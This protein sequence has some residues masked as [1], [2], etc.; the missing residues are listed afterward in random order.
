MYSFLLFSI[1]LIQISFVIFLQNF[2]VSTL[3][4]ILPFDIYKLF[5]LF[6]H[7]YLYQNLFQLL[8]YTSMHN[9]YL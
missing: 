4:N 1:K 9:D 7:E 6:Y 3:I 2:Y 5:L 8:S